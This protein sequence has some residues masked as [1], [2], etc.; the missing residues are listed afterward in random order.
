M[1]LQA[2]FF[3]VNAPGHVLQAPLF[4]DLLDQY[5]VYNEVTERR[6]VLVALGSRCAGEVVVVG[7]AEEEDAFAGVI[8]LLLTQA[9]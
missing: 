5:R 8:S 9:L 2:V 3:L 4:L 6:S 7:R 1:H